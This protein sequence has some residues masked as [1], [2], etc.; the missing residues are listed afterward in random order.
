MLA[1]PLRAIDKNV[2]SLKQL[3]FSEACLQAKS[4]PAARDCPLVLGGQHVAYR[5]NPHHILTA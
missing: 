3:Y 1:L 2:F 4:I 5:R